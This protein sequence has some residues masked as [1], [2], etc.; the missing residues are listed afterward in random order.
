MARKRDADEYEVERI[1]GRR[2][3]LQRGV[4][5]LVFWK[6]YRI[7]DASWIDAK[8]TLNCK[9]EVENFEKKCSDMRQGIGLPRPMSV[10]RFENRGIASIVD[11]ALDAFANNLSVFGAQDVDAENGKSTSQANALNKRGAKSMNRIRRG[12]WGATHGWSRVNSASW[13]PTCMIKNIKGMLADPSL[14]RYFLVTWSD[15]QVTWESLATSA[16]LLDVL[17]KYELA[18]DL[19]SRKTLCRTLRNSAHSKES[20]MRSLSDEENAIPQSNCNPGDTSSNEWGGK[21]KALADTLG[22]Y[23][24]SLSHAE[25]QE[26]AG[27]SEAVE[28]MDVEEVLASGTISPRIP[29]KDSTPLVGMPD[30]SGDILSKSSIRSGKQIRHMVGVLRRSPNNV[31]ARSRYLEH[32]RLDMDSD[33]RYL[34]L[35]FEQ[36]AVILEPP[37]DKTVVVQAIPDPCS[38]RQEFMYWLYAY[39]RYRDRCAIDMRGWWRWVSRPGDCLMNAVSTINPS[40]FSVSA[41]LSDLE[42][43]RV[44]WLL[45]AWKASKPVVFN[46]IRRVRFMNTVAAFI[47]AATATQPVREMCSSGASAGACG[48]VPY[49]IIAPHTDISAWSAIFRAVAPNVVVGELYGDEGTVEML[50]KHLVFRGYG[51]GELSPALSCHVVIA[52]FEAIKNDTVASLLRSTKV[53][54]QSIITYDA[55]LKG[56][57]LRDCWDL[58]GRLHSR[59][60]ILIGSS[61][62]PQSVYDLFSLA[63]FLEPNRYSTEESLRDHFDLTDDPTRE[64]IVKCAKM[65][66]LKQVV[67]KLNTDMAACAAISGSRQRPDGH[68]RSTPPLPPSPS[69][70][71]STAADFRDASRS[72]TSASMSAQRAS[73]PQ[74]P[75]HSKGRHYASRKPSPVINTPA[76][77]V[78]VAYS[79]SK[80]SAASSSISMHNMHYFD[81]VVP[82]G[83]T[84]WQ[85]QLYQAIIRKSMASIQL[86]GQVIIMMRQSSLDDGQ[87]NK[88][89]AELKRQLTPSCSTN[90]EH[91]AAH[92]STNQSEGKPGAHAASV[93][94]DILVEALKSTSYPHLISNTGVSPNS[95]PEHR[96]V[97]V[98]SSAK[99]GLLDLLLPG[100]LEQRRRVV[101]FVQHLRTLDIIS[102]YLAS[103]RIDHLRIDSS[104]RQSASQERADLSNT[105][106]SPVAILISSTMFESYAPNPITADTVVFFDS[107]VDAG[108]DRVALG[109]VTGAG[110]SK[111]VWVLRLVARD[112]ADEHIVCHQL[113]AKSGSPGDD[114]SESDV[115]R[116]GEAI[117][118]ALGT[119]A[120]QV[121]SSSYV[122]QTN[123]DSEMV[124]AERAERILDCCVQASGLHHGAQSSL[125]GRS[126]NTQSVSIC[127][128]PDSWILS[129]DNMPV[130]VA[131]GRPIEF[132]AVKPKPDTGAG[133]ESPDL[134]KSKATKRKA[135]EAVAI[136]S[137]VDAA[138][139]GTDG[140]SKQLKLAPS[141]TTVQGM[142]AA[143]I[144]LP[145]SDPGLPLSQEL[146]T[147]YP[148]ELPLIM[149]LFAARLTELYILHTR[150]QKRALS[151][152]ESRAI[153]HL[154]D[155]MF[156]KDLRKPMAN[157]V[158]TTPSLF[159]PILT[160]LSIAP[161]EYPMPSQPRLSDECPACRG[162]PHDATFC[163]TICDPA[164][165][166]GPW[167]LTQYTWYYLSS[168][169]GAAVNAR[170]IRRHPEFAVDARPFVTL[171][172][173][174][175]HLPLTPQN[176]TMELSSDLCLERYAAVCQEITENCATIVD[177]LAISDVATLGR[178][179]N[180]LKGMRTR[181][182][183]LTRANATK[184]FGDSYVPSCAIAGSSRQILDLKGLMTCCDCLSIKIRRTEARIAIIQAPLQASVAP[185]SFSEVAM[186]AALSPIGAVPSFDP[187]M[188]GRLSK[189]FQLWGLLLAIRKKG[190]RL[191]SKD[192][193]IMDDLAKAV[194]NCT[195][196]LKTSIQGTPSSRTTLNAVYSLYQHAAKTSASD[197]AVFQEELM[198]LVHSFLE[199]LGTQ[200]APASHSDATPAEKSWPAT[201]SAVLVSPEPY[202]PRSTAAP[203]SMHVSAPVFAAVLTSATTS[204]SI[205]RSIPDGVATAHR[206]QPLWQTQNPRRVQLL[207][208][209][210]PPLLQIP[211]WHH[212]LLLSP[213]TLAL[214]QRSDAAMLANRPVALPAVTVDPGIAVSESVSMSVQVATPVQ[215][216]VATT[217]VQS[218]VE[219]PY[220]APHSHVSSSVSASAMPL[221][222][223]GPMDISCQPVLPCGTVGSSSLIPSPG[224]PAVAQIGWPSMAMASSSSNPS[225]DIA[226]CTTSNPSG[227]YIQQ[228]VVATAQVHRTRTPSVDNMHYSRASTATPSFMD[229]DT[230]ALLT[231]LHASTPQQPSLVHRSSVATVQSVVWPAT[232]KPQCPAALSPF[233]LD[234]SPASPA[235]PGAFTYGSNTYS[236][237]Q[238]GLQVA[239][240]QQA[241]EQIVGQ[242]QQWQLEQQ[243]YEQQMVQQWVDSHIEHNR[244][245]VILQLQQLSTKMRI[246]YLQE[247]IAPYRQ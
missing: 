50:L 41:G 211:P 37:N 188:R 244:L 234:A 164:F 201:D 123:A 131:T 154:F 6:G 52:D 187:E 179:L 34:A 176:D 46:T 202:A 221:A 126:A 191:S 137:S 180:E 225:V 61:Q 103:S 93:L 159:F 168:A 99:L 199:Q 72:S 11:E 203:I 190:M 140:R 115:V 100:L 18:K 67:E 217:P 89:L 70:C 141:T 210:Q 153:E 232:S 59:Q 196:V 207:F 21:T 85:R 157:T 97:L 88:C 224:T 55:F 24:S 220:I 194:R 12:M 98:E 56:E 32:N 7:E 36:A 26:L 144:Q 91:A 40:S 237:Y 28:P 240:L 19:R 101:I 31:D 106:H 51:K 238:A 117:V 167:Y 247:A 192:C 64:N 208:P 134:L 120:A 139:S 242:Q 143:M 125:L 5:Y 80:P 110:Q 219:S 25:R 76:T 47:S 45:T 150:S 9:E 69:S 105:K 127:E 170:N 79:K 81:L 146:V 175:L 189:C 239:N 173:L 178:S 78:P 228:P 65:F 83:M 197:P 124:S 96:N 14:R 218:S 205:L 148:E 204:A 86:V 182:I 214:A 195:G 92:P 138:V 155:E 73:D 42:V 118:S 230:H 222:I 243:Q 200:K 94:M 147:V 116:L 163:P 130:H 112:T 104:L 33:G 235:F 162:R 82:V 57:S 43:E 241:G 156:D 183:Q 171:A 38:D 54:W 246:Q 161:G 17:E 165:I 77:P 3:S 15:G 193:A 1:I 236:Q 166:Q 213:P 95:D 174:Q 16:S 71:K 74:N 4:E 63:H 177:E 227:V 35:H 109:R 113:R 132:H 136:S 68:Q 29:P 212:D 122:N 75:A 13:S 49:L 20:H 23:G 39:K 186:D 22:Q 169:E 198:R 114:G 172:R 30:W 60:Y 8:E 226:P 10:D 53:F 158:D 87:R 142:M 102:K 62:P 129:T 108:V 229:A 135:S 185:A 111:F 107:S 44:E 48:M 149:E 181:L 152:D 2:I 128:L 84:A 245:Q 66:A 223:S 90:S 145:V 27:I 133:V 119:N 206:R 184:Q 215:G 209:S 151:E 160:N 233:S 121:L 216:A 231:P 58:V